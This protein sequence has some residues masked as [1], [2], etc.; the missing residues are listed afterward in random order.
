MQNVFLA[1]AVFLAISFIGVGVITIISRKKSATDRLLDKKFEEDKESIEIEKEIL[2]PKTFIERLAGDLRAAEIKMDVRLF[3]LL[4]IL[5]SVFLYI[6]AYALFKQPLVAIAPLPFALYF[7]PRTILDAKKAKQMDT[8]EE[9]LVQV[10]RRMSSVLKN[11]S[12]LQALEDV[13][14]LPTLSEKTRLLLNEVYHRYKYGDTIESA[15]H[16]VAEK[17][18]SEQFKICAISIHINK[19]LGADLSESLN[20]ISLDIQRKRMSERESKS[21]MGQTVAMGR[22]LSL[23]PFAIITYIT[24]ANEDYF[25]QYLDTLQHQLVFLGLIM[26]MFFGMFIVNKLSRSN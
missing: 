9:E 23:A 26:V 20:E 13:K 19:E 4:I 10:L 17:S 24:T 7:V 3:V 22:I 25:T 15:F 12:I 2:R 8:F 18:G 5:L 6:G 11:G 21:L 16:I 14:D 1:V